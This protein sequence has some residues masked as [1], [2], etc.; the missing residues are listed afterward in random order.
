MPRPVPVQDAIEAVTVVTA[1][2]GANVGGSGAFRMVAQNS[3]IGGVIADRQ[4]VEP[5]DTCNAESYE[6]I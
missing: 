5:E 3:L 1:V 2:G 6:A 4:K